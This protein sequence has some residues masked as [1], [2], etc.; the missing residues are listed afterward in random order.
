LDHD[1]SIPLRAHDV[2]HEASR[3]AAGFP[4]GLAH[5]GIQIVVL[6]LTAGADREFKKNGH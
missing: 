1:E 3:W 4:H 5:Q 2:R 6:I